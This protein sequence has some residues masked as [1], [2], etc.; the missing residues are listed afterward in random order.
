MYR[1]MN[2]EVQLEIILRTCW[3]RVRLIFRSRARFV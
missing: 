2:S 3:V 1:M